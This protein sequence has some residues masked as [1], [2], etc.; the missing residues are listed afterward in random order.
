M[1]HDVTKNMLVYQDTITV[2]RPGNQTSYQE[3]F[4]VV[5]EQVAA[6]TVTMPMDD[7]YHMITI[8]KSHSASQSQH[9]A[10]QEAWDKYITLLNLIGNDND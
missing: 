9:P 10:V 6:V 8:Y 5:K 1:T 3:Q 7:F 2:T 4:E